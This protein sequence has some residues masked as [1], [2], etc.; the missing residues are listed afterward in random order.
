MFAR[1]SF[2][3]PASDSPIYLFAAAAALPTKAVFGPL[4]LH[5]TRKYHGQNRLS[6][7]TLP[8]FPGILPSGRPPGLL[9]THMDGAP[10]RR[11]QGKQE[12]HLVYRDVAHV[13]G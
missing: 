8:A 6:T 10:I 2:F 5:I 3:K 1:P 11:Q 12:G 9:G 4:L 7:P 13:P